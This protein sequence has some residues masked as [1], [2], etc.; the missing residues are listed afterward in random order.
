M[1]STKEYKKVEYNKTSDVI[2]SKCVKCLLISKRVCALPIPP[3]FFYFICNFVV[4][5]HTHTYLMCASL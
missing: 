3:F 5:S 2:M 4:L 1:S